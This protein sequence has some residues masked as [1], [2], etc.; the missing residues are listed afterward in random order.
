MDDVTTAPQTYP[1]RLLRILV[2][3][4]QT[5]EQIAAALGVRQSTVSRMLAGANPRWDVMDR[6]RALV[7]A[8]E[9]D[10]A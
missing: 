10:A 7:L 1:Q 9:K 3:R 4:G 8:A 2:E 5:Q 6:L